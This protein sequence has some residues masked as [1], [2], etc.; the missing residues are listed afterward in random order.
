MYKK[1]PDIAPPEQFGAVLA[2]VLGAKVVKRG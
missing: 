1:E 2:S